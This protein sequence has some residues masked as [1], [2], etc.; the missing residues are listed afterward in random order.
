[1][2]LRRPAF[3]MIAAVLAAAGRASEEFFDRLDQ[4]LTVHAADGN[5]RARLSGTLDLEGYGFS[6]PAPGFIGSRGDALFSPRLTSFLDV[7]V[8]D[9][10]YA[11][12]QMRVDRGFDPG[13]RHLRGRL[14]EY[15]IR[16]TPWGDGRVSAQ[17]GKFGTVVGNWVPR[18][19]SWE[20]AF[21]T[22]PLAY[23]HLT[24]IWDGSA[25]TSVEMLLDWAHVRPRPPRGAPATD[26]QLRL[27]LLWGPSYATG[28]AVSGETGRVNYA[29]ELK[30]AG[31]ASRPV[32]WDRDNFELRN[33]TVSGRLGYR[34]NAMWH[35]GV[36]ASRGGYLQPMARA[37]L[38][39]G[40]AIDDYQH[41]VLAQDV[42]F[43]WHHWQMWAEF[44]ESRF[45]VPGVGDADAFSYYVEAK[46][47]V[48]PQFAMAAR[49]NEQHYGKLVDAAG[50]S[51]RWGA[52]VRR[53]D[54][55]PAYR[56]TPQ[57]QLK[58]QYSVQHEEGAARE[59][60]HLIAG[61]LT[62]RF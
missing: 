49:W 17:I 43:A 13:R 46:Y 45:T 47:K 2:K 30:D 11:F 44:F 48:T 15:A 60:S 25:A 42:S 33:P 6:Q 41:V 24:G 55:G 27:P 12:A 53:L 32:A 61:Q 37:T 58:L 34:P 5:V 62:V 35:F 18:H 22:A 38:P 50:D 59:W 23:E 8:G 31:L 1:M 14:D 39:V 54:L 28:V 9:R 20:S 7:Q 19:G 56:F 40:R 51:V 16:F 4:M 21:I 52:N 29:V 57:V 10:I 26:K 36:S 3:F